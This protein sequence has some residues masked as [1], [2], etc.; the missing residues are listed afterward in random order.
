[1]KNERWEKDESP[2][3]NNCCELTAK[4]FVLILVLVF[5]TQ[6]FV[7]RAGM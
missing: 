6:Y 7:S 3:Q 5:I 1:M 4:K 2:E